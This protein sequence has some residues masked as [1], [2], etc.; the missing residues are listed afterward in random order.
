MSK[1]LVGYASIDEPQNSG[2]SFFEVH[3]FIPNLSIYDTIRLLS[4]KYRKNFA[5]DCLDLK[6]TYQEMLD[7]AVKVSLSLKELDIKKGDIVAICMPNFYQAVVSFLACNRIGAISTFLNSGAGINEVTEYLNKFDSPLLINYDKTE[8]EN[9]LIKNNSNVRH[10]ITL[11]KENLIDH[12]IDKVPD[13]GAS[14]FVDYQTLGSLAKKQK[15]KIEFHSSHDDALILFTS[16]STG[17]PKS[18]VLRNQ[19]VLAAGIYSKNTSKAKGL[20]GNKTLV[21]VPFMYPYGFSTSTIMTLLTGK[22][23]ILAPDISKDTICNYLSKKP[24]IIFGSPALLDLI[25]KNVPEKMDLS[26]ITSF[27]SGGDFL[28]LSH[29][30]SAMEFFKKHGAYDVEISNGSGN[31]ETVSCGTTQTGI[32]VRPET[33]GKI[34]VGSN[35]MVVDPETLEE[36]KYHEE[37]LLCVSG[38]HVFKEYYKEPE[39]TKNAKFKRN[40]R[41]YFKT[42]TLGSIDEDG[43]FTLTGRESRFYIMSS[44]NKV[45]LDHVQSIISNMPLIEECAVVKVPDKDMLF[46]NKAYVVLKNGISD[47]DETLDMIKELCNEPVTLSNGDV[48]QLKWYEIPTYMEFCKE[49]PRRK[50]TDKIDYMSLEKDAEESISLERTKVI[51]K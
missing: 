37:G 20:K 3:P 14:V 22:E 28:T 26:F 32:K 45:Y 4:L 42:G 19:N 31:A 39:L 41:E 8:K 50:G 5:I 35:A 13:T 46:V 10:I 17:K 12:N 40:G 36:K 11:N 43:Y 27:I 1:K 30:N 33:V 29:Y 44:L 24:N 9:E 6:A 21:C 38:K 47:S 15:K 2:Y 34:L 49:L 51:K 48:E 18:V 7:D 23:A 25:M 16:G